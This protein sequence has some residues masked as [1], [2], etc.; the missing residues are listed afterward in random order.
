MLNFFYEHDFKFELTVEYFTL[1]IQFGFI[2]PKINAMLTVE[3]SYPQIIR[4]SN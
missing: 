2:L 1:Y 4:N 3:D